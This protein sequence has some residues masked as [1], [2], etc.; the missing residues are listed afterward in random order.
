[1]YITLNNR[2]YALL[3]VTHKNFDQYENVLA[4]IALCDRAFIS[5]GYEALSY[6]ILEEEN[7]AGFFY[8]RPICALFTH[9]WL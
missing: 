4:S 8:S 6:S 5:E 9:P 1:M 3:I 2:K 7:Y